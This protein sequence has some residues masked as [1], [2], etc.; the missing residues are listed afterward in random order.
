MEPRRP[1]VNPSRRHLQ[2]VVR[3]HGLA[4]VVALIQPDTTAAS[5]VYRR[6]DIQKSG[7]VRGNL[8]LNVLDEIL[9]NFQ[10]QVAALFGMELHSHDVL[11]NRPAAKINTIVCSASHDAFVIRVGLVTVDK[12]EVRAV[13]YCVEYWV[14]NVKIHLVPAHMGDFL[15]WWKPSSPAL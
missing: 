10:A 1:S 11:P 5:Q 7:S 13:G 15:A 8:G 2:G 3:V 6:N 12:I 9:V 4:G 14:A